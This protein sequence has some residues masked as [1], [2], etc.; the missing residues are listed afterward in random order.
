MKHFFEPKTIAVIGA[1]KKKGK[2]GYSL[3]YNLR[4]F[5]GNVIPINIHEK[6]ILGKK[7]YKTVLDYPDSLDLAVIAVP[8]IVVPE[9]LE[10]C[11]KKKIPAAI[12]ISA[13]FSEIG[14]KTA[15]ENLIKIAKKNNIKVLGPNCFGIVNTYLGLDTTFA[16]ITP[17]KGHIAFLSQS[18]AIWAAI[19]E[20]SIGRIG[21]SKFASLGNMSDINFSDIIEECNKNPETKVIVC[22]IES[23]KDG[24]RFIKVA[25]ESKK[26]IIVVKAGS[27]EAGSR[28]ALSHTAS[29]ASE[30]EIYKAAFKQANVYLASTLTEAFDKA[31]FLVAQKPAKK[32]VIITNGGGVGVL[33]SDYCTKNNLE[34]VSL[35]SSFIKKLKLNPAWSKSNPMDLVGTANFSDYKHVL[36][37]LAKENFYDGIIVILLELVNLKM[38]DIAKEIVSFKKKT[39]KSVSTIVIGGKKAELAIKYLEKNNIPSFFEPKRAADVLAG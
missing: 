39:N 22:Y 32:I 18:G 15:E 24:Q 16:R 31:N 8:A 37:N 12:I 29:I 2:V 13:G 10:Q 34:V 17:Q 27:S 9:V 1:S 11:G 36:E 7:A 26:P 30:Y 25:K 6:I 38:L 19:A 35:P 33:A 21:F 4:N 5:K 28:A 23:L 20:W 14:N 3:M